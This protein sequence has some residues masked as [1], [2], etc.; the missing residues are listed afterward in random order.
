MNETELLLQSIIEGIQEK[1]GKDI[2]VADLK[3][4]DGAICQ[5]FVICQG[6]SPTQVD[7]ITESVYDMVYEKTK[8]RPT[9]VNGLRN[10]QWVGMDY[11][12]IL[13]HIFLPELRNFY[14]L[15]HL[16]ADSKLTQVPN[17]D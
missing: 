10:A 9:T 4:I 1:K 6:N 15:E 7:A 8:D 16:W 12:S 13:V 17:L 2:V 11:G 5:Y 3:G 14:N